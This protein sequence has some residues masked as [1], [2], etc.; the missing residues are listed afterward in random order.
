MSLMLSQPPIDVKSEVRPTASFDPPVVRP[1]EFSTYRV[2]FNALEESV[3]WPEKLLTPPQL[4]ALPGAHG[5]VL[6][7]GATGFQPITSFNYRVRA[8]AAGQF[9]IPEFTVTV[10]QDGSKTVTVPAAQL[11]VSATAP[12]GPTAQRIHLELASTNLYVGQPVHAG[13]LI[14]AG[15][16][17]T[18]QIPQTGQQP[19]QITGSGFI[20]E[21]SGL[22]QR[23]EMR[24]TPGG[25]GFASLIYETTLTPITAGKLTAFAQTFVGNRMAGPITLSGHVV[26]RGGP[27]NYTLVESEPIELNVRPL[28][29]DGELPGFTGAVGNF[30]L[31]HPELATNSLVVGEPV[32]FSVKVHGE[33][34][35]A[36][37]VAPPPPSTHEW[38]VF[39][40]TAPDN[41]PP[42][43]VQAQ[44][45]ATF[46]YT[47]VALTPDAHATPAIPFSTFDPGRGAY[48]NLTIPPVPVTV[49]PG[50]APANVRAL[51]EASAAGER[52]EKEPVLGGLANRP[53]LAAGSL[54]PVQQQIWFPL[55][56]LV[57][58]LAFFGLWGWDRRRRYLEQHPDVV[59]R[60]RARR[61]L[62]REWRAL[63]K[64]A[65]AG[66]APRFAAAAIN[67]MRAA[68]APHYP[69]EPRAL[70][71]ND[72]LLLLQRPNVW[73][74]APAA[75]SGTALS[76]MG[77]AQV[78]GVT[79]SVSAQTGEVVRRFFTVTDAMRFAAPG[80]DAAQLL[81][82][83]S[84]LEEVLKELEA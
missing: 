8:S 41:T 27:A 61:A 15:P 23:T 26:I 5:Q 22:R 72:V 10:S 1:G 9:T 28:P 73:T 42:Q 46:T 65:R 31:E 56:Q 62:R 74:D 11:E 63:R 30:T 32:K 55:I 82:L 68:S 16:D 13:I 52:V 54:V 83:Q 51:A 17:G 66:D 79:T 53:G 84:E 4:E 48:V 3:E 78:P 80:G 33:G 6:A 44:G 50:A 19:F 18:L 47:L 77:Q 43:M 64:A 58:A 21:Q 7:L 12:P 75:P 57:P 24:P 25:G 81:P 14:P 35:L 76:P 36:R 20:V 49:K 2:V 59:L 45:F 69:A 37:L 40:S 39:A 60:R 34:N 71:G 70:V 38:Q 29:R 67:A